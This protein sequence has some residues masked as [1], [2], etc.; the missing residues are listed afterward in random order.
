MAVRPHW[1]K[2]QAAVVTE[3]HLL[4]VALLLRSHK[5]EE[6]DHHG[7][8][9]CH[10]R[11][12][13]CEVHSFGAGGG[14]WDRHRWGLFVELGLVQLRAILG[15]RVRAG[16]G[17]AQRRGQEPSPHVARARVPGG[18][19]IPRFRNPDRQDKIRQDKDRV[20]S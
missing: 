19:V 6:R 7:Q 16:R 17:E 15:R 8:D 1:R 9:E 14:S 4:L 3:A 12:H 2:W 20:A 18:V 10:Y 11:S 13:A 5:E